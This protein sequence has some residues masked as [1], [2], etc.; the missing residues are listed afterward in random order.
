MVLT[1]WLYFRLPVT[2]RLGDS[3]FVFPFTWHDESC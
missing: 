3:Q 2:L 1:N